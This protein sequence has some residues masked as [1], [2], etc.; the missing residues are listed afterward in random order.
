MAGARTPGAWIPWLLGALF[1]IV[2]AVNGVMIWL[3]LTS[4]T[5]LA[6]NRPYDRGL[7]YNRNLDAAIRQSALGWQPS[8]SVR[9]A[10]GEGEVA[11]ELRDREGLPVTDAEAA[12]VFERPTS[13][14]SDFQVVLEAL[15]PGSYRARFELPLPG[16]WNL[17]VTIRRGEDLHVLDERVFL[18]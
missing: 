6:T 5:G 18:P 15:A 2:V 16:V 12:V 13:E 14:G 4:W 8:L 10:D 11:L 9:A 17:H 7:A 1:L 3:A